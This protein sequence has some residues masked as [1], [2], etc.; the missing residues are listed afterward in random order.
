MKTTPLAQI[1]D[2]PAIAAAGDPLD[3]RRGQ[4]HLVDLT[5]LERRDPGRLLDDRLERQRLDMGRAVLV[6]EGGSPAVV[7][8][9][10]QDDPVAGPP[11]VDHPRAGEDRL[12]PELI[13]HRFDGGGA[14]DRERRSCQVI[15]QRRERLAQREREGV[16]VRG[17]RAR[18]RA[19]QPGGGD[20]LGGGVEDAIERELHRVGVQRRSVVE[21]HVL[22][23]LEG[24][25][26]AVLGD[27]PLRRQASDVVAIE[28]LRNQR[29]AGV[30]QDRG[31]NRGARLMGIEGIGQ[32]ADG[33]D[34]LAALLRLGIRL[35]RPNRDRRRPGSAESCPARR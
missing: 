13:A 28:V 29:V 17:G 24:P 11:L 31:G 18:H 9:L 7:R 27:L 33:Q 3:I 12:A 34:P 16:G 4:R 1:L 26:E 23:E 2:H 19:E 15:E 6:E 5:C 21:G 25:G 35:R 20:R 30:S 14:D 32:L 8:V 10:L 22:A